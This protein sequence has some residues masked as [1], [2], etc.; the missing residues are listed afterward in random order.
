MI[1]SYQNNFDIINEK[2]NFKF[3]VLPVHIMYLIVYKFFSGETLY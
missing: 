2:Y 3:N 1:Y